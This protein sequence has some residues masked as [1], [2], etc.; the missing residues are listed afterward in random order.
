M[1]TYYNDSQESDIEILTRDAHSMMRATNQPGV[2][3]LIYLI[4][5]DTG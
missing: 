5:V 4:S 2:V 3:S 1:F